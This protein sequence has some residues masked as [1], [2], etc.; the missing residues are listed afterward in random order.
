VIA[1]PEILNK[2]TRDS[3]DQ[4]KQFQQCD[5]RKRV[6]IFIQK[7][8]ANFKSVRDGC[9]SFKSVK[10]EGKQGVSGNRKWPCVEQISNQY[11]WLL[12]VGYSSQSVQA[13]ERKWRKVCQEFGNV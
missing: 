7:R 13:K 2:P 8:E 3:F 6:E 11:R 10:E 12:V 5:F 1:Y 9:W 4:F